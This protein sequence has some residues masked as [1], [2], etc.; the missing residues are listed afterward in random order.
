M[1]SKWPSDRCAVFA[2]ESNISARFL[3]H[4]LPFP[5]QERLSGMEMGLQEGE[6]TMNGARFCSSDSVSL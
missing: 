3:H 5:L 1:C 4:L 2:R 6:K